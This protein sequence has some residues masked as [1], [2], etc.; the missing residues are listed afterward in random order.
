MAINGR[1]VCS[2]QSALALALAANDND[3]ED[4]GGSNSRLLVAHHYLFAGS[5]SA[6]LVADNGPR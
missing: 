1:L 3:D 5:R 2:L 4:G 6:I